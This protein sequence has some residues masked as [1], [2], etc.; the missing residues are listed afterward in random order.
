MARI[1]GERLNDVRESIGFY[2]EA[3]AIDDHDAEAL[4]GLATLYERERRWPALVE[5]LARQ[6]ENASGDPAA[7]LA[8]L[9]RRG[10]LL[11]ERLGATQSAIAVFRRIQALQPKN[12]RATRALREIYAQAG[13]YA[14]LESL[15]AEH[16]AFGDLCDQLTS[17]ADRTADMAAR[18]RLLE[19]VALI[20]QEKL[21]QPERALKAYERI[22]ATDPRNR[23]AALALLPLYRA[24]QKW[25]RLLATYEALLGP[26]AGG[27]SGGQTSGQTSGQVS[28]QA[29]GQADGA[30]GTLAERL[31]LFTEARRICEQRLGSKALAF[32]WCARAFE[33]APK[34]DPVRTD[35]ERLAGEADEWG[36]L[37]ALYETRT[38]ASSDAE[39]RLW[40]LR[41]TLRIASTRLFR[42]QDARR[43][44]EQILSELGYDEEADAALEQ[45][46]TQTKAWGDL[47]KLLHAR[48]DRAP[49]VTERVR[50]LMK[51]APL[52]EERVADL[53][54]AAATWAAVL[55]A[56]PANERALRALVRVSEAR[57]DWAG[58]VEAL[59]R[60]LGNRAAEDR[61]ER[62][63]LLLRIAGLQETRLADR[64]SAFASYREV[65][66]AN[67]AAAAAVA[68]LERLLA[69]GYPDRALVARLTQPFYE[70]T[71]DA[72]KLAAA[73]EALL[74]VA[75]TRGERVERLEKL[76]ALYGGPLGDAAGAYRSARALFDLD[77]SDAENRAALIGFAEKAGTTE[78]M[79]GKLRAVSDATDD[80]I[81]RRDLLVVVAELEELKLGRAAE[82]EK[83]YAKILD[84][85]PLHAGAFRA[86]ARLYR[87]G[88]RWPELR[89]LLDARQL[90]SL[91]VRERLDLLAEV[92]ELDESALGDTDHAV[93]AYEKMLELDAADLRAHR[94]LDRHYAE[95]ARW[96]DLEELLATR[97]GFAS[98]SEAPELAF[99]R[100]ELRASHLDDVG[101]ALELLEGIVRSAPGHEG[102]RRLLERLL[103]APAYRQRVARILAPIYEASAAWARLVAILEVQREV[104]EGPGAA[105]LLAR[106]ADLQEN[107]LQART[108]ALATWRQVLAADP[109]NAE[110]LP[111]IERLATTLEKFSDLVDVYQELAFK[112]DAADIGGRADLLSRAARL[113]AGRLGNRRAAIDVWKLAL[114]VAPNDVEI[115]GPAA[116]ALETLYTET[117]DVP[118]LVKIL[119]MQVGWAAGDERKQLLYRI[120]GLEEKSLGDTDGAVATLRG[121]LE[122]DPQERE[123]IDALE[124][125]FEA[126]AQHRQRIEILRKRIDLAGDAGARQELWRRVASLLE[127]DVG[128]VDEAIAACV[129]ILDENPEDDQALETLARLYERQGRHRDR[130]EI[131]ERRLALV[132]AGRKPQRAAERLALSRQIAALLEGPLGDPAG[133]LERWQEVLG[134]APADA[135]ALA[136]LERFLA[137]GTDGALR[138][139]AAQALE[140]V[141]E[142]GGRF[143]ELAAVVRVYIEAQTDART[144][145]EQ[146]MRLASLE[147]AQLGDAEAARATTARAIRD[148]L[149]E[150]ELSTLLDAYERLAGP[151]RAAEVTSFYR[152]IAPDVLDDA[153]KLRL[154]RAI[155]D[156]AL[157]QGDRA[158]ATDYLRRIL[159]RVPDDARALGALEGV[160][161]DS[162]DDQALYEVL[163]RR[164]ELAVDPA[165]EQQLRAELGRLAETSLER[166]DDA[167]AAHER[168]LELAPGDR[169]SADALDRLYTR[170]ERWADLTHLVNGLIE[171][172]GL[173]AK[174]LVGLHFRLAEIEQDRRGDREAALAELRL[175]LDGDPEHDGAIEMLE[176]MLADTAVQATAAELLEP[177]YARR[178][179]WPALIKIGEIRL[180]GVDEPAAR[181]AWSK[182]IARLYEEQLEDFDSALRWYGK[183]FQE[184]PTER[185]SLEQL[186]RLAGKLGRW[187]EVAGLLAGYLEGE[188]GEEPAVLEIVRRTAAIFDLELGQRAEAEKL[189]R[190]LYDARPDDPEV[191]RIYEGALE[192]WGAWLPLRELIDEQAGRAVEPAAR[193]GL[194]RR[195]AKLDEER[196]DDRDRA[197][198]TLREALEVE[199]GDDEVAGELERLLAASGQWHDLADLLSG[200]LERIGE[201]AARSAVTLRLAKI[202]ETEIGDAAAA[203]DRYAEALQAP[204]AQRE[205][206]AA[207]EGLAGQG[208]ERYRIAVILGPVYRR[209]GDFAR[210][211]G[212]LEAELESVDDRTERVRILREMA[213]IHE[214]TGRLDLAF[215]ARSRAWLADVES[216]ETLLEM[217]SLATR[218]RLHGP[219]VA[220]LE[221]G[222]VETSDPE[223]QA[224]LWAGAAQLLEEPL[225]RDAEAVD[226]W[227]S[228]LAARP[229]DHDA[230]LA[231][232]RLF[233]GA[234]RSAELVEVLER[235]LEITVDAEERKA[236]A[237]RIAVLYEDAL[238]EREQAVRAW[239]KVLEI[240]PNEI[241]AL[242]SL[243]QLHLAGGSFRELAQV[244]ARKLELTPPERQGERRMLLMLSARL[245]EGEL[246][247]A[248]QAVVELRRL[249]DES[250]G[251]A[252]A[253]ENLDRILTAEGRFADLVEV[254]DTR[255]GRAS[256]PAVRAE[257]A[258]RA[259]RLVET[260]LSDVEG[261]IGR[262]GAILAATPGHAPT[263]EALTAIARGDDYRVPAIAVL[264]PVLRAARDW[265]GVIEALELRLAVEDAPANRIDLLGEVARIEERERGA[266]ERAF[267]V[268]ARALAEE[269][270][271]AVAREALERLAAASGGWQRLAE[272]YEERIEA[273]FD[274]SL[275]LSL[276]LRL[277]DLYETELA[278][279][280]GSLERAA[281]F[282][283]KARSLPG[284]ELAVLASLERVLGR[285]GENADLAE[286]LAREAELAPEPE[287]QAR[288]L[289]ALGTLRL[290][291]LDDAE[292]ALTA[293]RDA[294]ERNPGEQAARAALGKLADRAETREGALDVLEPLAAARG[295]YEELIALYERRLQLHDDRSERAH[296][297]RKIA[298]VASDQIGSP[299]RALD[300]LGRALKEE[301]MPGAALDDLERIAGAARLPAVGAAQIELALTVA[302]PDAA[303]ELALRAAR[304]YAEAGDKAA[305]ERLYRFVLERDGENA[306]ALVA[307]EGLYRTSGNEAQLA[308]ILETRAEAELDPQARRARLME[309][310][311]LHERRGSLPAAIAALKR[312]QAAD[313]GDAEALGEL[314]RLLEATGQV[315]E[316]IDVLAERARVTEEP[317]QRAQVWARV[318]ELRLGMQNDLDGA[319]EAYREALDGTPDDPL[320]LSALEAIEE[321]RADWSTLQE[322]LMRRLGATAGSDQIAVLLKLARNA[323][324]KLSD[325][326]QAL[327]FLRQ[328]LDLDPR[329]GFTYLELE[330][331]MRANDRWYDLVE[332]LGL[333]ADM[334]AAAGHKPTELA[335]R[336]AIADVWEKELDSP[337]SAA[338]AIEKVLEAAPDNVG[339]L[340]TLARLH[341]RS[342]RWDDAAAAL[343]R[344]AQSAGAPAEVAEIQFRTAEALRRKEA[345]PAEIER[346]LLRALDADPTHRPT[347]EALEQ[348]ARESKDDERLVQLLELALET[349]GD[350]DERRKRLREIAALYAGP[351][352]QPAAALPALERLVALDPTEIPGREQ[353]AE[354]LLASGRAAEAARLMEQLI[355]ELG[356]ARRGK[357]AARWHTRLGVLAEA[358]GDEAGAAASFG[359]AYRLDPTH[360]ATVA[361][362]G[363]LAFRSRD[364]DSARK[365]YRSLLLQ[366]FDEKTA[367]VSKSEVYLMLG[368]MHVAANELS[369]ARNMFERGLEVE[370]ANVD[371]KAALKG[372]S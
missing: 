236:M 10:T 84:A 83:V 202:L 132:G 63:A 51:I 70:R 338:E 231:L 95:R 239:E 225:G 273:T 141:Y 32:Q 27:Q 251:D 4:A 333:H 267:A 114:G 170:S 234:A 275:Q 212:A 246:G 213:D 78:E 81:L 130:L 43:A 31:E 148:A 45:I 162:G 140:P 172:G 75:D 194:L 119:R 39:E 279:Q 271:E 109:N 13:D 73:T 91:D 16:G 112:R 123:A 328:I 206:Q 120:A 2:N 216:R 22:L 256:D 96:A 65:L 100:A 181:I 35:L 228:V 257:L 92:A 117:G 277:A 58:V 357:D 107:R 169:E 183:V 352:A 290:G 122:N 242:E 143:A 17:L 327:G 208:T 364:F 329:N 347:L 320:A 229:D 205:A 101:G 362:L 359:A 299:D 55:E 314:G 50:L 230:F 284:D 146:L 317:R 184:A 356:K 87:A 247:E 372:L 137:P 336:V 94:A 178:A 308:A 79:V 71:G 151:T 198:G 126:G 90:A 371:L 153:V 180:L 110:A 368:R 270:G 305:A 28:N 124:R 174:G 369:K 306:D 98:E 304:L 129:S 235:H 88:A 207:L 185:L 69:A 297:L 323:E 125:I 161:R 335:L 334:E 157:R 38:A 288:H 309:A 330:R 255:A 313:D 131:L 355:V 211:A 163:T 128:D 282:L 12:A 209:A 238:K 139:G 366:N 193:I 312:L 283:R 165:S 197:I 293:F 217:E 266:A 339:A 85:E 176:G 353:L 29:G 33:A 15:Y 248:E 210:L 74:A 44:A 158:A 240:D 195:S 269:G 37:A 370:P 155:A 53:A 342:E 285:Q 350:D 103:A 326:D 175:V 264:E 343:E 150:P 97:V 358:R 82:A 274:A 68:G 315:P 245:Y 221:K 324:Q 20:A 187:Q 294:L 113:Y 295:D 59:R 76:R 24:A 278:K 159:D 64:D 56:E 243:A 265:P 227:R 220:T 250:P 102:A 9:E 258:F 241:E 77:P 149:A 289:T 138:L 249:L 348:M 337:E 86:L 325:T 303:Q 316:L 226:A 268:W 135:E 46:L 319:A 291:A 49:D 280:P 156:A 160:F 66:Q 300:A 287:T 80:Q 318:G 259:A 62:E 218:A 18:T 345:E 214:R 6:A 262:Y 133:A 48:A 144:R 167:I 105:A 196:L 365:Y 200:R 3:L 173:P 311:R 115:A 142:R 42:P 192:R 116:A 223:L 54:A 237:K 363:R 34:N 302:E 261:A 331:I 11:Y 340:L 204:S 190:R 171:R 367:G 93:A 361:A 5:I 296:F 136:A 191:T 25:P 332:V 127:R 252:E 292:G 298:E 52:E 322:V 244:Y 263:R 224:E 61:D 260:E 7:E 189:Y 215:E 89:A 233:S 346:A 40:L 19:R 145:L 341:E 254:V 232:E 30:G 111:Q 104:V 14:A 118:G 106:C 1:A 121:I 310:A 301:P 219:L 21:S 47:A 351:L 253:L 134:E 203:V 99:R 286:V 168:V 188:L 354:A 360:P 272:V 349:A 199:P 186:L 41:R 281:D 8:L 57:Q 108:V 201:P 344:A 72:A 164:A 67:A 147:E 222:A 26:G 177:V 307:L 179:D 60:D 23:G 182:R 276:A 152:D 154:D 321:R 166:V 36:A